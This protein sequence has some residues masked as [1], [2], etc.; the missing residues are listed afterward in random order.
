[1]NRLGSSSRSADEGK[2]P[3]LIGTVTVL[4]VRSSVMVIVSGT[5]LV[6]FV[7]V[8]DGAV[9][10]GRDASENEAASPKAAVAGVDPGRHGDQRGVLSCFLAGRCSRFSA[11]IRKPLA[12]SARVSPGS[13]TPS[14]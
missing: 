11:R 3:P 9:V 7:S 4:P 5:L 8:W 14:I 6:P 1:M 13:M 12:I 2:T 10:P